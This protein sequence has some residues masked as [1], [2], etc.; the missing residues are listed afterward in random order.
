MAAINAASATANNE[1]PSTSTPR[2]DVLEVNDYL[3]G[4]LIHSPIDKFFSG[5]PPTFSLSDLGVSSKQTLSS[6]LQRA[7]SVANDPYQMAWQ[8][9]GDVFISILLS[10]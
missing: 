4:G 7:Q 1:S 10:L 6:A 2:H 3:V 8:M 5:P 9:V